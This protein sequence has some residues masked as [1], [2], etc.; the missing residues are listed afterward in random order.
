MKS[1]Y[2]SSKYRGMRGKPLILYADKL[3]FHYILISPPISVLFN[4]FTES[5][6]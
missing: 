3:L 5:Y 6:N 1:A 2:E 4:I